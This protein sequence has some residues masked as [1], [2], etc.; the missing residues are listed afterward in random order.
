MASPGDGVNLN[1][2]GSADNGSNGSRSGP[3]SAQPGI[4]D[5][6]AELL[7]HIFQYLTLRDRQYFRCVPYRYLY[8]FKEKFWVGVSA[9][10]ASAGFSIQLPLAFLLLLSLAV[11]DIP[12]F[13]VFLPFYCCRPGCF[14]V[15]AI[16]GVSAVET[17]I[18]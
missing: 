3:S 2:V 6:S 4:L 14:S 17:G 13:L 12:L 10:L 9:M 18:Q 16:V 7:V 1:S 5:L 11:V 15:H 8:C